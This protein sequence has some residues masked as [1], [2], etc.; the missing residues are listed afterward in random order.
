VSSPDRPASSPAGPRTGRLLID[1]TF[2]PWFWGNV[3]SNSGNWLF[4]VVAAVVVFQLT[5]SALLVG[6]VS[7]AQFV[8]SVVLAP[9]TG[10]LS[11]RLDRRRV[12]LW[13]QAGSAAAAAA[14][15]V[16]VVTMGVD[17]LPGAW[18][19]LVAA[20]GIGIGQ[21]FA[22]TALNALVPALV[23]DTDLE[24]GVALTSLTFNLGRAAGPAASGLL[25]AT[26]GAEVA[27]VVNAFSFLPL[28]LAL[29]IIRP[30]SADEP[31]DG[32]TEDLSARAGLRFVRDDRR[33]LL[34]LVAVAAVGFAIDP[35]ITLAPPLAEVLGGGDV[36]VSV[37]VTGF[38]VAA[39][40][41]ALL[42][43]RLQRRFG[44]LAVGRGG[45]AVVAVGLAVA[46]VAPIPAVAVAGFA[47][48]GTGFV[49]AVTSVTSVLQRLIPDTVRG[50]VMALWSVAFLGS[51][52][53]AALVDG[54]ASDRVG[55][56][57]TMS[58]AI[59]VALAAAALIG[60]LDRE[61]A[62]VRPGSR[63]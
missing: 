10:A 28:L 32:T 43:S 30:R 33:V 62:V 50:R 58:I 56:R 11:D 7:V 45:A 29:L 54:A 2:G 55:P 4:N 48:C 42:S 40:P 24:A 15:A 19:I 25:L 34:I 44:G 60:R 47:V 37:M 36:L 9:V 20:G 61:R 22:V 57:L 13:A 5:R 26:F 3:V 8:P 17:G 1:R 14:L 35:V 53:L 52:P 39:V 59:A 51:R 23:D 6:L 27:F 49:L 41:G 46:A 18:P 31:A 21:A 16:V 63:S 12:L 38:G